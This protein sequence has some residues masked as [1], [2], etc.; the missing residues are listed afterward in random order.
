MPFLFWLKHKADLGLCYVSPLTTMET[1]TLYTLYIMLK[2][3][4]CCQFASMTIQSCSTVLLQS[5]QKTLCFLC[6]L[7]LKL[8]LSVFYPHLRVQL[9]IADSCQGITFIER[10]FIQIESDKLLNFYPQRAH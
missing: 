5:R 4:L 10:E 2:A 8:I 1:Y 6:Y 3:L 9:L 7:D